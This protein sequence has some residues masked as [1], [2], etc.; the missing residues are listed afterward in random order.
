[1][2]I[3]NGTGVQMLPVSIPPSFSEICDA[4][5]IRLC[6]PSVAWIRNSDKAHSQSAFNAFVAV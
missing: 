3:R 5:C 1:M 6:I 4:S 2:E